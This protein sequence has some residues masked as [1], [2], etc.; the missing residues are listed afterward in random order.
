MCCSSSI[1]RD[2]FGGNLQIDENSEVGFPM[3]CL[4]IKT[5]NQLISVAIWLIVSE[6]TLF[7]TDKK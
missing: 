2:P 7:T 4:K 1:C 3:I 6:I 5:F